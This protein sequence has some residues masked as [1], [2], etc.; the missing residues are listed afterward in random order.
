[1]AGKNKCKNGY[2]TF[3]NDCRNRDRRDGIPDRG[4]GFYG[5]EWAKLTKEE[6][7]QYRNKANGHSGLQLT[8]G[9]VASAPAGAQSADSVMDDDLEQDERNADDIEVES[10][11]D[12]FVG[13]DRE[14]AAARKVVVAASNVMVKT[15]EG[16]FLP[17]EL[18]LVT[19]SLAEGVCTPFHRFTDP[20]PVPMGYMHKVMTH[21]NETHRIP[22]SNF[23]EAIGRRNKEREFADMLDEVCIVISD[24]QF[25]YKGR[26]CFLIFTRD[27]MMEQLKGTLR[28]YIET[29]RHAELHSMWEEG[30]LRVADIGYLITRL[31]RA[32]GI[33]MAQ[34]LCADIPNMASFDWMA[35]SCKY[36]TDIDNND[37]ALGVCKRWCYLISDSLLEAYDIDPVEGKHLPVSTQS[38]IHVQEADSDGVWNV[39]SRDSVRRPAR[40]FMT[41]SVNGGDNARSLNPQA[42]AS[43]EAS[44]VPADP[45]LREFEPPARNSDPERAAASAGECGARDSHFIHPLP[46]AF[47]VHKSVIAADSTHSF[48]LP[49]VPIKEKSIF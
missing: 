37:C 20:G 49:N 3:L 25:Q 18:G 5:G 8:S 4:D 30:R 9:H 1:M 2:M 44:S 42:E 13:L 23:D 32:A 39:S 12:A 46:D 48:Q 31:Y 38:Q 19:Y 47:V 34:P 35:G 17:M 29:A 36:H 28:H 40:P 26:T 10:M 22:L 14:A 21:V 33:L 6:K 43:S 16:K 7:L 45:R 24:C 11:T 41:G 15:T 27:E